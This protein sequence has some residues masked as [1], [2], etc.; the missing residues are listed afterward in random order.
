MFNHGVWD[1]VAKEWVAKG[2]PNK[3]VSWHAA[4]L[5]LRYD[6]DGERPD[7]RA[8][9]RDPTSTCRTAHHSESHRSCS[10][11]HVGQGTGRHPRLHHLS[12]TRPPETPAVGPR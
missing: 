1:G 11:P 5:A 9:Y 4:I 12:R 10:T 8:W 3:V 2:L 6:E 7:D